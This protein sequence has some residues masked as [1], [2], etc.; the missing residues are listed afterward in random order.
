MMGYAARLGNGDWVGLR[1]RRRFGDACCYFRFFKR[2]PQRAGRGAE[3]LKAG[4]APTGPSE[5]QSMRRLGTAMPYPLGD[6]AATCKRRILR[7]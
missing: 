7:T 2:A 3:K 6:C 4:Q 1:S 5:L